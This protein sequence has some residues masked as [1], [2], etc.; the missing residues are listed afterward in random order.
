ML[1]FRE[2][3]KLHEEV[4]TGIAAE[5]LAQL[6]SRESVKGEI[7]VVIEGASGI[8]ASVDLEEAVKALMEEGLSGTRQ[9]SEA[10]ARFGLKRSEAYETYLRLKEEEPVRD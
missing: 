3:T 7:V 2:L 6:V 10:R 1:F 5:I 8:E 4:I 9:A